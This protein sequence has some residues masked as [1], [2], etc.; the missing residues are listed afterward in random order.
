MISTRVDDLAAQF[1]ALSCWGA[2]KVGADVSDG[3]L[4][5][6]AGNE[7]NYIAWGRTVVRI[8]EQERLYDEL[9]DLINQMNMGA[10]RR[11]LAT[12]QIEI[13]CFNPAELTRDVAEKVLTEIR[14][15]PRYTYDR[16]YHA[17]NQAYMDHSHTG[18][19]EK[20]GEE[21]WAALEEI[22]ETLPDH[23]VRAVIPKVINSFFEDHRD[24]EVSGMIMRRI[25]SRCPGVQFEG[26]DVRRQV[27]P[28]A[29]KSGADS[30][31][32]SGTGATSDLDDFGPFVNSTN[33]SSFDR[34]RDELFSRLSSRKTEQSR[35]PSGATGWQNPPKISR[36]K[37]AVH[38]SRSEELEMTDH[39]LA[40]SRT[41]KHKIAG[42]RHSL[43]G[44]RKFSHK[45]CESAHDYI[46]LLF[47][48]SQPSQ[49]N[50]T[51]PLLTDRMVMEIQSDQNLQIE[52]QQSLDQILDFWGMYRRGDQVFVDDSKSARHKWNKPFYDHNESRVSRVLY[53]LMETGFV[54]CALSMERAMNRHRG[55][56]KNTHWEDAVR[57]RPPA[58]RLS[59]NDV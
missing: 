2:E 55:R 3:P 52:L 22:L 51:A 13:S 21:I 44:I 53:H 19:S 24:N 47:P 16:I 31:S 45:E 7:Q 11:G 4:K 41:G 29:V 28:P 6:K 58:R 50:R 32:A 35:P 8:D 14:D 26:E 5:I 48:N 9:E 56:R 25:R 59:F 30:S 34:P 46:Q 54:E 36:V 12:R 15:T 33:R 38:R 18:H 57:T 42:Q 37:N 40:F 49:Y 23:H 27:I 17:M 43:E 20:I 10:Q 1:K 39:W